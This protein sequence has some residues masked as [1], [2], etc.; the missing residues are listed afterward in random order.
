MMI[1]DLDSS[2]FSNH[3]TLDLENT[4]QKI[5]WT[6]VFIIPCSHHVFILTKTSI[7]VIVKTN[8][9]HFI[10]VFLTYNKCRINAFINITREFVL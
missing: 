8:T 2:R 6:I 4:L 9:N 5:Y 3:Q 7:S 10:E 1:L